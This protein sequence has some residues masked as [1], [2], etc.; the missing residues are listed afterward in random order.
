MSWLVFSLYLLASP[1][2]EE[3][4]FRSD[5]APILLRRCIGC[6]RDE[7]RQG[8]YALDVFERLREPGASG[9]APIVPGEP[10][11]SELYRRVVT[12]DP[13]HRMPKD[14]H[15]L[16]ASEIALLKRWIKEGA[17]YDADDASAPLAA[18][19]PVQAEPEPPEAYPAALPILALAF[20]P[21]G[22]ELASSGYH[23]VLF[24][25]T[26]TGGLI[27]RVSDLPQQVHDL[28]YDAEGLKLA[29]CGG[30]PGVSGRALWVDLMD[31][32]VSAPLMRLEDVALA[33]A[34]D[35]AGERLAV[36]AAE[37]SVS[38]YRVLD[39]AR[40]WR[41]ALHSSW[42]NEVAFDR[43]GRWVA[44]A[45]RD[46]V[47]KVYRAED[48]ELFTTYTGHTQTL[49]DRPMYRHEVEA[50]A[51]RPDGPWLVT[52]GEG[53]EVHAW[54]PVAFKAFD[55]TAAQMETRFKVASPVV[56]VSIGKDR[57]LDLATAPGRIFAGGTS[58]IL[59]EIIPGDPGEVREV[60]RLGEWI[61]A[62]AVHAPTNR[63]AAGTFDGRIAV[64]TIG[65]ETPREW[66]AAPGL[67]TK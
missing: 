5:L 27:D 11:S 29:V 61:Y 9:E 30:R 41:Q 18:I 37:G 13:D 31:G 36:S 21:D 20:S 55:G 66:I 2:P 23:E 38:V 17:R 12:D 28:D 48:G 44:S 62:V 40:L 58:G 39:G 19:A 22:R 47:V 49:P 35:P 6:H 34:F 46:H 24:W 32:S 59:R 60:G 43:E 10:S 54:D 14:D 4:S 8:R 1:G 53:G 25:D 45:G 63:V 26:E 15:P 3:V 51:F 7:R 42:A 65:D 56:K 64:W 67:R 50:A 57:T 16:L 33:V 52:A